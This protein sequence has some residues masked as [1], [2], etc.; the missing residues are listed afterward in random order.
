MTFVII[1]EIASGAKTKSGL[2]KLFSRI[3]KFYRVPSETKRILFNI[4]GKTFAVHANCAP[5]FMTDIFC[6][7]LLLYNFPIKVFIDLK[8]SEN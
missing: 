1:E 7:L 6:N 8:K 2:A 3:W 4:V 5:Y